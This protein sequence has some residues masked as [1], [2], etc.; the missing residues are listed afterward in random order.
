MRRV[1]GRGRMPGGRAG[2][3]GG[4]AVHGLL[5]RKRRGVERRSTG[6]AAG[7]RFHRGEAGGGVEALVRADLM[8][9]KCLTREFRP[10]TG[11]GKYEGNR[12]VYGDRWLSECIQLRQ[13]HEELLWSLLVWLCL[14]GIA[15]GKRLRFARF[16]EFLARYKGSVH[17]SKY[18][19]GAQAIPGR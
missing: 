9:D 14:F 12:L 13:F 11:C 19:G 15:V 16:S 8:S 3:A 17:D 4:M 1:T 6:K 7:R 10:W 2:D 18:Q 5:H